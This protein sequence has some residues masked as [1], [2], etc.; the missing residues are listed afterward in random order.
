MGD[1][2]SFFLSGWG[3]G[4]SLYIFLQLLA[5]GT[6]KKEHRLLV[7]IPAIP[8]CGIAAYTVY[9]YQ[10]ESNLWPVLMI[11]ASPVAA[12]SVF[13]LWIAAFVSH[14]RARSTQPGGSAR[15]LP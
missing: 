13:G 10:A 7:L 14:R 12:L 9:A 2:T 3:V 15:N 4:F 5:A 1:W 11:F 6:A 8:M